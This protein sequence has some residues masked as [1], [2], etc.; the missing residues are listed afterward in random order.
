MEPTGSY[1]TTYD[2]TEA[3]RF[4]DGKRLSDADIQDAHHLRVDGRHG[5]VD[6]IRG[7]VPPLDYE[8]VSARAIEATWRGQPLRVAALRSLVGFKRLSGRPR[9]GVD[10]ENLENANGELPI[11]PIPGLDT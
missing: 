8:T 3:R 6:F 2:L 4:P 5:V 9:D 11:D 10:L 1:T 7:R